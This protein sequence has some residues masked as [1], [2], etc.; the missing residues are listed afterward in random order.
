MSR[1]C[2]WNIFDHD[3]ASYCVQLDV[4]LSEQFVNT[5]PQDVPPAPLDRQKIKEIH[6]ERFHPHKLASLYE[7]FA[8]AEAR[9]LPERLKVDDTPK[10]GRK[11]LLRG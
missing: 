3:R 5:K 6:G 11:E 10:Q 1:R 4:H 2:H 8:P 7:A 9:R